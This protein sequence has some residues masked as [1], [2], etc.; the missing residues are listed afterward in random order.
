MKLRFRD[1]SLR[2]RLSRSE[3]NAVA[4]RRVVEAVVHFGGARSLVYLLEASNDVDV[5]TATFETSRDGATI[6]VRLPVALAKEWAE[7]ETVALRGAMPVEPMGLSILVEKDFACLSTGGRGED[8]SDMFPHPE[9]AGS[10]K[11][12]R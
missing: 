10:E 7:S 3:V 2:L 5:L 4:D 6:A 12:G 9:A 11:R 8:E 1:N